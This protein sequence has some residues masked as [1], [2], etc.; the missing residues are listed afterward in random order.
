MPTVLPGAVTASTR[1]PAV[2]LVIDEPDFLFGHDFFGVFDLTS[3]SESALRRKG[4]SV[5]EQFT[6]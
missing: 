5:G 2:L 4:N 6:P 1:P 3:F